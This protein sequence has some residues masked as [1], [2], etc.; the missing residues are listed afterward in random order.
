MADEALG[1]A[2]PGT[3]AR[4]APLGVEALPKESGA[5]E[6]APGGGPAVQKLAKAVIGGGTELAGNTIDMAME[7]TGG[8]SGAGAWRPEPSLTRKRG[9]E[10]PWELR[11]RRALRCRRA[12]IAV[13]ARSLEL[14][15]ARRSDVG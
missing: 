3:A 1:A 14:P 5:R 12:R 10:A 7:T 11:R 9:F 15:G 4:R 8:C 2:R 13:R 6:G